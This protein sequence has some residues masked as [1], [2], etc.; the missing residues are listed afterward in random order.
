MEGKVR[1][2]VVEDDPVSQEVM[3]VLIERTGFL[4][5]EQS[6]TDPIKAVQWLS[7][8]PVD[9]ILLDMEMPGLSGLELLNT[10]SSKP[11]VIIISS[12]EQYAVEAFDYDVAAYLVKPV[13]EF[14][15]F[16]KATMRVKEKIVGLAIQ[17]TSPDS[18][19]IKVDS[20]FTHLPFSEILWVEAYGDYVKIN[21]DKKVYTVYT[22]MKS[23]EEKLSSKIFIRIHRSYLANI[24]KISNIDQSNL[25]IE[26]KVLPIGNSYRENLMKRINLL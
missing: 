5:L 15:K 3:A 1:C 9:L 16:L 7:S 13:T 18:I 22:T 24:S 19:Y 4:K 25:Q 26:N 10:I 21:T 11:Q 12:K 2:V 14:S 6:F 23:A 8:N 20:L 17:K